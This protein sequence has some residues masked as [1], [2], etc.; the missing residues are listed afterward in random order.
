MALVNLL[1]QL[2]ISEWKLVQFLYGEERT[3]DEIKYSNSV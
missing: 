1:E 3:G 2:V